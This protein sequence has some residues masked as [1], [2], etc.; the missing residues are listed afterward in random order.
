MAELDDETGA[1]P[2]D[3][4]AWDTPTFQEMPLADASTTV[5]GHGLDGV[6]NYS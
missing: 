4:K 3:L 5:L 2:D 6:S 1:E